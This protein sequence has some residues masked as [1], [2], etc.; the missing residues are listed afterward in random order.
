MRSLTD[1]ELLQSMREYQPAAWREFDA[2]FRLVLEHYAERS[3]IPDTEWSVCIGEVLSEE[4]VRLTD[5]ATTPEHLTGYLIRAVRH[6]WMRMRRDA[7]A[8]HRLYR[9]AA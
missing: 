6:R 9:Y 7:D 8:R 4:A 1:T 5:R 3:R 2:R